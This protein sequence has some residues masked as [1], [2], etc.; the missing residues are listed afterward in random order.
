MVEKMADGVL[1]VD[2]FGRVADVNPAGARAL[3][4][5]RHA[6][7]G[8]P[9]GDLLPELTAG[10]L[11]LESAGELRSYDVQVQPLTDRR[12]RPAGQLIVLRDM[13]ERVRAEQRLHHL[14]EER[15]RVAAALQT[16]LAPAS[17]PTIPGI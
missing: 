11:A 13:T 7:V 1:M 8:R 16:S 9:L 2:A 17:L 4:R 3:G 14:L 12:G 10:D 15:S 5:E 6:L